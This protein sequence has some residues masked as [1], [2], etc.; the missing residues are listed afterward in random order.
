MRFNEIHYKYNTFKN[1]NKKN[2]NTLNYWKIA[3]LKNCVLSETFY[4]YIN[5]FLGTSIMISNQ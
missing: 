5:T 2:S 1:K 4:R 3:V